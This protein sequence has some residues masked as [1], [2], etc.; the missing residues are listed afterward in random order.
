METP[1]GSVTYL[2]PHC[3]GR[4]NWAS[5]PRFLSQTKDSLSQLYVSSSATMSALSPHLGHETL[6][7]PDWE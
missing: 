5:S 7:P 6:M 4:S 3:Q 1:R 2:M